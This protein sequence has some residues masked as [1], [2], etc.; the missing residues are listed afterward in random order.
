MRILIAND[1]ISDVG[2]VQAYLD[3]VIAALERR[4][5]VVGV[6]YCTDSG[7]EE[8]RAASRSLQKFCLSERGALK[9]VERWAP[10]ICFSHNMHDLPVELAL[11]SIAPLVKFM[12]GY[13]G[14]CIGGLKMHAFPNPVA[15]DRVFGAACAALY[16]PRRCGQ[17]SPV[18]LRDQWRWALSQHALFS[19]YAAVVVASEHMRREY[20]RNGCDAARVH[21][22]PLFPTNHVEAFAAPSPEAPHVAFLGRMTKLKGGDLL[23][24][25]IERAS[26]IRGS[27]IA[28]TMIGDGPQRTEWEALARERGVSATFTG[29]L[30]GDRRWDVLR[31]ASVIAVPSRW[32]EP[33]GFVGLEAAALGVPAIAVNTGGI[34]QWLRPGINGVMVDAPA[35]DR[36]FGAAL[37]SVLADRQEL[38]K[39]RTGAI[40]IARE[41]TVAAHVDRLENLFTALTS[42]S[43]RRAAAVL[44]NVT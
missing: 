9:T 35:S 41:M 20:I 12:H 24:R 5:H 44:A 18:A 27:G 21:V 42:Q 1:G 13:F 16:L 11:S 4:G 14:T 37:A 25:A 30:H 15:C 31:T 23:V 32:P 33:F 3:V 34:G 7:S 39:L 28:L 17:L 26:E 2:G 8:A 10:E 40:A 6:G 36:S 43:Q 19:S 22:N 38:M 29:W